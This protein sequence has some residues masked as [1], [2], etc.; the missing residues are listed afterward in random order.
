M[1]AFGTS[2]E[3]RAR[4]DFLPPEPGTRRPGRRAARRNVEVVDAEFVTVPE[5]PAAARAQT[6]TGHR[7]VS[8]ILAPVSQA[9]RLAAAGLVLLLRLGERLLQL[10]PARA[11]GALVAV[12]IAAAFFF[13]GGF[14]AL[15][16]VL[17]GGG[18]GGGLHVA[19][20]TTSL[21]DR[22]GMKVLSVYGTVE[23]GSP[24]A[25]PVPVIV[26]DM[27]AGGRVIARHRIEPASRSLKAGAT[28]TFSL[29]VPHRGASM[30]K[31]AVSFAP[32]GASLP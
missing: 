17:A 4:I 6:S 18:A 16:M 28:K 2:R 12:A 29:K 30:P 1:S 26:V 5:R 10:L 25:Q 14:A 23:N 20:V 22:N 24:A 7:A 15:A 31:V 3:R 9:G 13:A 8:P 32:K 21:D 19:N 27:I 11:F